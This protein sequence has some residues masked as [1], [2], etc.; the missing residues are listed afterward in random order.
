MKKIISRMFIAF[1]FL[2]ALLPTFFYRIIFA[3]EKQIS[4]YNNEAY[5]KFNILSENEFF[6]ANIV[7]NQVEHYNNGEISSFGTYGENDDNGEFTTIQNLCIL[8]NNEIVVFDDLNKLHFFDSLNNHTKTIKT[9]KITDSQNKITF[10]PVGKICDIT[11][12]IYSN[13]YLLDY[14]NGYILKTNSSL[15]NFEVIKEVSVSKNAKLT[16]LN[17]TNEIVILDENKLSNGTSSISLEE[18]SKTIFS[19]A[20]NFVYIVYENKIEKYKDLVLTQTKSEIQK[21]TGYSINLENGNIFYYLNGEIKT[22]S[23]F[24]SNIED[25]SNPIDDKEKVAL[26]NQVQIF[27]IN[28]NTKLLKNPYST[29][30][31]LDL[32]TEDYV[33]ELAKTQEFE[34]NFYYVMINKNNQ[35]Y[36]GY[37]EEKFLT[38]QMFSQINRLSIPIRNDIPYYKYPNIS[39]DYKLSSLSK[40]LEVVEV[41]QFCLNNINYSTI[42]LNGTFVYVNSNDLIEAD[43]QSISTY[44]IT[45][46]TISP[47]KNE[48]IVL[49]ST[50]DKTE[51]ITTISTKTNIKL[52]E[53]FEN[54]MSEIEILKDNRI[55]HA[56]IETKFVV[57]QNDFTIPLTIILSFVCL[58]TLI[59]III[60]F[61]K[62]KSKN[63]FNN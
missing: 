14:E 4:D 33:I 31:L 56:F 18:A 34:I 42:N 5:T 11:S 38:E 28:N 19:D 12:D 57:P 21:G 9:I 54:G 17:N 16:I 30:S 58:I 41:S 37:L 53:S 61:K 24:A 50:I 26:T 62:D 10:K 1:T 52:I 25:F 6:V 15:S 40:N 7:T 48:D 35:T 36:L 39:Q 3:E 2:L 47:Y 23:N 63:K 27:K 60:K 22:I 45:N 49:Y 29:T 46:A 59:F 13:V 8:K 51:I 20:K 55:I 32:T 43:N 44:L